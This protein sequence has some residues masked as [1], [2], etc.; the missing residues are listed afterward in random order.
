MERHGFIHGMMDVK[1]LVLYVAARA[2]YPLT[3]QEIYELSY[4]DDCVSYFDVCTAIDEMTKSG[5]LACEDGKTYEITEKG[6]RDGAVTE[7]SI[8]Y[9]VKAKAE[10]AVVRYNRER[11]RGKFVQ[12][13]LEEKDNGE[14]VVTMSLNDERG[15]LMTLQLAAPNAHQGRQLSRAF[16]KKAELFY[17]LIMTDLLEEAEGK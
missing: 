11:H 17:N 9:T 4:Q 1:I 14:C 5:H 2:E 12:T 16:Q 15:N 6:R 3:M 13:G 10:A 7:D 8:A